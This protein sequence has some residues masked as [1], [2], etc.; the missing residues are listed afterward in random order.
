MLQ[1][2][3]TLP[4][5]PLKPAPWSL[6]GGG[7]L[8]AL[9][10][11]AGAPARDAFL[12]AE[13]TGKVAGISLLMFVDYAQSDSGPYHELLFIPGSVPFPDGRRHLTISRILVSTWDS[14][15]NGRRNW[16]IPKDRADFTTNYDLDGRGKDRALLRGGRGG[17]SQAAYPNMP[18]FFAD[19]ARVYREEINALRHGPRRRCQTRASGGRPSTS[20]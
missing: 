14:V 3:H 17:V 6:H 9:K 5:V 10:L 1:P 8:V 2:D 12:P 20:R 11:P 13:F 4:E 7:W 16:G 15:V 18:D 19:L